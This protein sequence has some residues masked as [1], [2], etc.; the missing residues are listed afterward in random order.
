MAGVGQHVSRVRALYKAVLKLHRGLP[1][2]MQALGDQYVREEFRRH[3]EAGQ[4][5]VE[6]FMN[7][8]TKYYVTLARQLGPK[9]K[10]RTVGENL[11]V[12]LMENFS[13]EQM[14]QLKE[15]F[16]ATISPD[17]AASTD[18]EDKR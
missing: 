11:S 16:D 14:G 10:F 8:W 13:E 3:K 2:Q 1:L 17:A 9:R 5:E 18:A 6:V 4:P 12:E 15:L 7:E